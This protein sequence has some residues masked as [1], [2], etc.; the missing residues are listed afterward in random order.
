MAYRSGFGNPYTYQRFQAPS[1]GLEPTT[2]GLTGHSSTNWATMEFCTDSRTR[3]YD[4]FK[5]LLYSHFYYVIII[6]FQIMFLSKIN[7]KLTVQSL[8]NLSRFTLI[9]GDALPAE[10]CRLTTC[11]TWWIRTTETRR[12][13]IY[14][15]TQLTTLPTYHKIL[16]GESVG[17]HWALSSP[18]R[19]GNYV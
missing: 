3:T 8:R 7:F 11:G 2:V 14:S 4:P 18:C 19:S 13:L 9:M 1:V 12:Y 6:C 5:T 15:Q 10:L 17:I 16:V